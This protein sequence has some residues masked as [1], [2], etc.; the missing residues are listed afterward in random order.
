MDNHSL[1]RQKDEGHR[2]HAAID[3]RYGEKTV[4]CNLLSQSS[5]TP[6]RPSKRSLMSEEWERNECISFYLEPMIIT[7][8]I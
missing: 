2:R 6:S 8:S 1:S 3:Q 5:R 4:S 7:M